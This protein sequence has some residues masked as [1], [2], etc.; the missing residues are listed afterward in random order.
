M[1]QI[2]RFWMFEKHAVRKETTTTLILKIYISSTLSIG[3]KRKSASKSDDVDEYEMK[4]TVSVTQKPAV[5][6]FFF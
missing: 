4:G 1:C 6:Q 5:D 3:G 2:G